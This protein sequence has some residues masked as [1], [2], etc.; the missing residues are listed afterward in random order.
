MGALTICLFGGIQVAHADRLAEVKISRTVKALLAYLLLHRHRV[1]HREVLANL[2][3][4]DHPEDRARSCL[5]T[6]LWRLRCAL[7]PEDITKGTYLVTTHSGEVGFNIESNYWLDVAIFEESVIRL[8]TKPVQEMKSHDADQLEDSLRL[9]IG[10]LMEGFYDDWA[11]RERERLSSLYLKTLARLMRYHGCH[12]AYERAIGYGRQILSQD[13]LREDIHREVM[14]LNME[15]GHR[16]EAIRH[17]KNCC[18]ILETELGVEPMEETKALYA[19]IIR[20]TDP[21]MLKSDLSQTRDSTTFED[22]AGLE[23][24]LQDLHLAVKGLEKTHESILQAAQ[25]LER[26]VKCLDPSK[27]YVS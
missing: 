8:L 10:E 2:F 20:L 1:H 26:V 14:R 4:G 16:T 9:Y 12:R 11:L 17:F 13:P 23:Q 6:A 24:A 15:S 19:K 21:Y 3:W 7:E 22:R 27:G 25:L 18:K 5:S